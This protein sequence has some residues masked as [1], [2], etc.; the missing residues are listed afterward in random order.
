MELFIQAEL[1]QLAHQQMAVVAVVQ[2]WLQMAVTHQELAV[3]LVVWA[4]VAVAVV[5][6]EQVAQEYFTFF[7]RRSNV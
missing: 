2:E 6:V 1:A 5:V 3:A 7:T 4:V